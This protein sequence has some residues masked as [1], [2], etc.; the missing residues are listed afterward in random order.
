MTDNLATI[1]EDE[2]HR[3]IGNISTKEV[4]QALSHT[5]GI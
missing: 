1:A 4:D 2:I 5:L 3:T